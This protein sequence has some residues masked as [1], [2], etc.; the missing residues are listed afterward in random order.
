[1][2]NQVNM[3]CIE[4]YKS[5]FKEHPHKKFKDKSKAL[6]VIQLVKLELDKDYFSLLDDINDTIFNN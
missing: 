1:M 4:N 6:N 3:T 2:S 5:K